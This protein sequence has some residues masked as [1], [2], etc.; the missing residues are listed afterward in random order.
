MHGNK[1]LYQVQRQ[2]FPLQIVYNSMNARYWT[3]CRDKYEDEKNRAG[4][5]GA[6]RLKAAT[7]VKHI[8]THRP[9]G[10]SRFLSLMD[11]RVWQTLQL[12]RE[13]VLSTLLGSRIWDNEY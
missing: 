7:D 3:T 4:P 6:S 5:E 10:T 13:A 9:A 2:V 11:S 12:T 1:V 8:M